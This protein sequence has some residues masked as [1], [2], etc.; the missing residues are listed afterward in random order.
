MACAV[1]AWSPV[2]MIT[3][4]PA[5]R[6]RRM[7]SATPARGGSMRPRSPTKTRSIA[8]AS[9]RSPAARSTSRYAKPRTRS[10]ARDIA[11]ARAAYPSFRASS[12]S[13]RW[14]PSRA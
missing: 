10:P 7:E 5:S 9:E 14:S 2:S 3:R 13:T 11:S 8:S 12:A 1:S 6:H 4:I